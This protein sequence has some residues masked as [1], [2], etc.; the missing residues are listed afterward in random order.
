MLLTD[1]AGS[2][3][4][5]LHPQWN[6]YMDTACHVFFQKKPEK[7]RFSGFISYFCKRLH[8]IAL[9]PKQRRVSCCKKKTGERTNTLGKLPEDMERNHNKSE[10]IWTE[11]LE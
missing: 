7:A 11:P 3:G 8:W 4:R 6:I 9:L 2:A 10:N 5:R 1:G